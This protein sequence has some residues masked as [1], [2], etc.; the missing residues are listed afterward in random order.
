MSD[1][2]R[3][4]RPMPESHGTKRHAEQHVPGAEY[5]GPSDQPFPVGHY[6]PRRTLPPDL[7]SVLWSARE[8]SGLS[9]RE[10]A[11][12]AG[13]DPSYLSKLVRGSRAPSLV[14]AERLIDVLGLSEGEQAALRDAAVVDRGKSRARR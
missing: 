10:V 6:P 2:L 12:R 11:E 1:D 13:I 8:R 4:Y 14:V 3:A 9:N 5:H 7:A